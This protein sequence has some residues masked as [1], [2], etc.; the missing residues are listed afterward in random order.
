MMLLFSDSHFGSGLSVQP[1]D[2]SNKGELVLEEQKGAWQPNFKM[3][4]CG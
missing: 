1:V 4:V 2:P 3:D